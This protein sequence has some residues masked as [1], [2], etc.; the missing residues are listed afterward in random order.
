MRLRRFAQ[1][2]ARIAAQ[3]SLSL[4]DALHPKG[5]R[6]ILSCVSLSRDVSL[7]ICVKWVGELLR[8]FFRGPGAASLGDGKLVVVKSSTPLV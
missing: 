6:S 3:R 5:T 2:L 8:G 7:H 4:H 1:T